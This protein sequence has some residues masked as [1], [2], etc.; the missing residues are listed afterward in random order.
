[1]SIATLSMYDWPETKQALDRFWTSVAKHLKQYGISPPYTLTRIEHPST[2]WTH[3]DLLVGQT[4]GWPYANTLRGK[5]I[6]FA[7][8]VYDISRCPS[9]HYNSVYIGRKAEDSRF[10]E[11]AEA[12]LSAEKIA[13]NG[14]DSQSGFHVF[15]EITGEYSCNTIPE[16]KR[17][18]TG[19]H[20]NS[21]IAVAEGKA[22]IAA[23]DGVS[24]E[25]A[26]RHEPEAASKVVVIGHSQPKPG[27]PLITSL[28]HEAEASRL[29]SALEKSVFDLSTAEREQLLITGLMA[30]EDQEYDVFL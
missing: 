15:R 28:Q 30:A 17:L 26:K 23:I 12:L 5:A 25:L 4:C 11:S 9:G 21:V 24:F 16:E 6:P 19:A 1:M 7:R 13:I 22:E 18:I 2:L 8:F 29:F 14:N 3:P 27:L 20:R 10:L